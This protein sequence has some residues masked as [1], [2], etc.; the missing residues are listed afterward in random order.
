MGIRAKVRS[1]KQ[2]P[3]EKRRERVSMLLEG[4]MEEQ[5]TRQEQKT[6]KDKME[7]PR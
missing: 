1:E 6:R 7:D 2:K 5:E 4:R 3:N